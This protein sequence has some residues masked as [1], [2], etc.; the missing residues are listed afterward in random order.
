[1]RD[2]RLGAGIEEGAVKRI[3]HPR[4]GARYPFRG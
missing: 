1:M 3:E 2:G 4:I